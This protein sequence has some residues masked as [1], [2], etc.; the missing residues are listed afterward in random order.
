MRLVGVE[1]RRLVARRLTRV[2]A[3]A[4][5]VL[6][7]IS[8]YGTQQQVFESTPERI[9]Q[10]SQENQRSC[11]DQQAQA[12]QSDPG[13]DFGCGNLASPPP[14]GE[15]AA[16]FVDI[17]RSST[18]P[19]AYLLV[20]LAFV[21]GATF[22]AAEF[23][24]G[25]LG[26]WLTYEPRRGRVYSSKLVALVAGVLVVAALALAVTLAATYLFTRHYGLAT[27][28]TRA[29]AGVVWGDS[30]RALGLAGGAALGGAAVAT[31]LRHTA[32]ALGLVIGYLVVVET[33]FAGGLDYL[34][35]E[36]RPWLLLPNVQAW[37]QG[38]LI[39]YRVPSDCFDPSTA[40]AAPNELVSTAHA[41]VYLL[42]VV[43]VAVA[44]G[45]LVFR[46]RDVA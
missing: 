29:G 20:F 13:A 4:L 38:G 8:L 6:I 5:V 34:F 11:L 17:T 19:L 16:T 12:R 15:D 33:L 44:V 41:G 25:A 10:V 30:L 2:A 31:L 14:S 27:T 3:I 32:A 45:A 39:N 35:G 1:L 43:G 36:P 24:T 42:V 9:A 46:R 37:L 40:C 22:I 7:G 26:M 23:S 28:S 21:V 18:P